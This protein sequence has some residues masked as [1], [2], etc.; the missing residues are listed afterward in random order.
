MLEDKLLDVLH[1]LRHRSALDARF[2]AQLLHYRALD[3]QVGLHFGG[4]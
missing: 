2:T 1:G 4:K 3:L